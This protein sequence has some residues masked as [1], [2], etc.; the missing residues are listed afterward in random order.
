MATHSAI[1]RNDL[2]DE[3]SPT[4]AIVV[5]LTSDK[6]TTGVHL[7][8]EAQ[9]FSP[10]STKI[11]IERG[12]NA[13]GP[14]RNDPNHQYLL[15]DLDN[16]YELIPLID[17]LNARA[18]SFSPDGDCIY[19]FIDSSNI[20]SGHIELKKVNPD[21]TGR[22]T[23]LVIDTPLKGASSL[24]SLLYPLS[25]ISSD[26]RKI[27]CSGFLGDGQHDECPWCVFVIDLE[28][29]QADIIWQDVFISNA[30]PQFSR[31]T[32]G[33]DK[34]N[35][36]IQ[37]NHGDFNKNPE[38]PVGYVDPLGADIHIIRDNATKFQT[39][40]LGRAYCPIIEH[41]Q[42]HQCWRGRTNWIISSMYI[43]E[44]NNSDEEK[45]VLPLIEAYP[46]EHTGHLGKFT[47][48]A[49]RNDLTRDMHAPQFLH[50][51]TD[52]EGEKLVSDY[53]QPVG[54]GN[55]E[56]HIYLMQLGQIGID[57]IKSFTYL[58]NTK[59]S[60][61]KETHAHPFLSPDGKKIFF[62]SDE[63]GILQAY[64]ITGFD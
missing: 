33:N 48:N 60:I 19:Y 3:K 29:L 40:G 1:L 17:E 46:I 9:V 35:L 53:F 62:N 51:S 7:Y 24:L 22:E 18:P 14:K 37:H 39:V 34:H 10:D 21:G 63:S 5:Q 23:L 11:I 64:M 28:T 6:E 49:V 13:H 27:A 31:S 42:G 55:V 50:F 44:Q 16:N 41:C 15:C 2:L 61:R 43:K 8:M 58:L 57:P 4:D 59:S 36:M 52:I 54:D 32:D 47:P 38:R 26:G 20:N 45:P 12:G 25:T 30:H 56:Q